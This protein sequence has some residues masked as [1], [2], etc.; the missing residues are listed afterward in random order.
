M[1]LRPR[2]KSRGAIAGRGQDKSHPT[3]AFLAPDIV[4][5]GLEG[6][7][8]IGLTPRQLKRIAALPERTSWTS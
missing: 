3:P 4:E 1:R 7:Q 2:R 6:R 8:P 5:V